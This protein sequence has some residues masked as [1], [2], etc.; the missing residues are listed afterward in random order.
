[1]LAATTLPRGLLSHRIGTASKTFP[2]PAIGDRSFDF[3]QDD[4]MRVAGSVSLFG[5]TAGYA[6]TVHFYPALPSDPSP[7]VYSCRAIATNRRVP[8]A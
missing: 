8:S 4:S 7:R 1:M 2:F 6:P 3:A 5:A